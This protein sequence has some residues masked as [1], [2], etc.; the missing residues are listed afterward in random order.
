MN[1]VWISIRRLQHFVRSEMFLKDT[2]AYINI[3][4][5]AFAHIN[6]QT[7]IMYI[8]WLIKQLIEIEAGWWGTGIHYGSLLLSWVC[9]IWR[10]QA[11]SEWS[12]ERQT[13][14]GFCCL[15]GSCTLYELRYPGAL[16]SWRCRQDWRA[17]TKVVGSTCHNSF[18]VPN[19]TQG[20]ASKCKGLERWMFRLLKEKDIPR[21]WITKGQWNGTYSQETVAAEHS[22]HC[23]LLSKLDMLI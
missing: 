10:R 11:K 14:L 8:I 15:D 1:R 17:T 6:L 4:R 9:W 20:H 2:H 22:G 12:E 23:K 3:I 16:K 21:G 19:I 18:E 13:A 5:N 7:G